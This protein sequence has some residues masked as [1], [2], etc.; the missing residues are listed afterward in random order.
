MLSAIALALVSCSNGAKKANYMKD[1]VIESI[2]SRRSIR[3]YKDTPVEREK[4][5]LLAECG[6]NAPN[7]M[8]KQEWEVR[9]VDD[10]NYFNSVT[11]L[12]AK[13]MPNMIRT[14]DP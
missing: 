5:Q 8:N 10:Q 4:L 9:I 11:D 12:M 14:D 7:A 3:Y 13:Y 2:M 6:V 1:P